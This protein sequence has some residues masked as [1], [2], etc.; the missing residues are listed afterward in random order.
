MSEKE[1]VAAE[2]YKRSMYLEEKVQWATYLYEKNV[3]RAVTNKA[4]YIELK[5]WKKLVVLYYQ[6]TK[7][8]KMFWM[9]PASFASALGILKREYLLKSKVELDEHKH[10]LKIEINPRRSF[11][12]L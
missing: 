12:C 3:N 4:L 7:Q 10:A 6:S 8:P 1:K 11:F 5:N 2:T 9:L